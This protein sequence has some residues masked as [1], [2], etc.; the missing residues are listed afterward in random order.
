MNDHWKVTQSVSISDQELM[1]EVFGKYNLSYVPVC[2]CCQR[3]ITVKI[4]EL[5]NEATGEYEAKGNCCVKQ[6]LQARSLERTDRDHGER[7]KKRSHSTQCELRF[8]SPSLPVGA[9]RVKPAGLA[10]PLRGGQARRGMRSQN[11]NK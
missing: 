2:P 4:H 6:R 11:G 10:K 1:R 8:G 5:L 7:A 9:S 3:L